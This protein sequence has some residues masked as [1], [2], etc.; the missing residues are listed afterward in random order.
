MSGVFGS[1]QQ[2]AMQQPTEDPDVADQRRL[3]QLRAD[4]E[5]FQAEQQRIA[6][7]QDQLGLQTRLRNQRGVRSLLTVGR[8]SL[9]GAG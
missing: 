3:E 6:S 2:P 1:K 5:Q 7:T 9:L 8:R 4:R